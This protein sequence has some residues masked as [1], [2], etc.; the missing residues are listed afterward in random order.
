[1]RDQQPGGQA[2]DLVGGEDYIAHNKRRAHTIRLRPRQAV[3][4]RSA[5]T[6]PKR[7][8]Q[9]GQGTDSPSR[10]TVGSLVI[11]C[12]RPIRRRL[13][14]TPPDGQHDA[15]AAADEMPRQRASDVSRPM[16]AVVMSPSD[17][18]RAPSPSA[19]RPP[20]VKRRH[21]GRVIRRSPSSG[22][23][24]IR[25]VPVAALLFSLVADEHVSQPPPTGNTEFPELAEVILN[26]PPRSGDGNMGGWD[27]LSNLATSLANQV[28]DASRYTSTASFA[29]RRSR[30]DRSLRRLACASD[31]ASLLSHCLRAH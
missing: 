17:R 9:L 5:C 29:R 21:P 1:V 27:F 16:I 31:A 13:L 18:W 19:L 26:E 11:V 25:G 14:A 24:H 30:S 2:A 15:L 28:G 3:R 8:E 4:A 23:V 6:F 10:M 22:P 12:L 20:G 7:R